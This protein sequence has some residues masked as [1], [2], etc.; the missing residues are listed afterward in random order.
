MQSVYLSV[1]RRVL[2]VPGWFFFWSTAP[3][4]RAAKAFGTTCRSTHHATKSCLHIIF[5]P[6]RV[7]CNL[8][9]HTWKLLLLM[10]LLLLLFL[11]IRLS[12]LVD[13]NINCWFG[14]SWFS[15]TRISIFIKKSEQIVSLNE[16]LLK[17]LLLF[18]WMKKFELQYRYLRQAAAHPRPSFSG[19]Y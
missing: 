7:K 10:L 8:P 4:W 6:L 18:F 12:W 19:H 16:S 1:C 5:S 9:K 15:C 13:L 14:T 3:L 11:L 17:L 2:C